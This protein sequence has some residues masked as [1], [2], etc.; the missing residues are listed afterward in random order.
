MQPGGP[1]GPNVQ[2]GG[3]QGH[4]VQP[5]GPQGPYMQQSGPQ[6]P[7]MQQSGPQGP[8]VQSGGPEGPYMQ[9]AGRQGSRMQTVGPQGPRMQT[10]GPQGPRVQSVG[11]QGPPGVPHP[12]HGGVITRGRP[13]SQGGV[14]LKECKGKMDKKSKSKKD[15]KADQRYSGSAMPNPV[16]M[17]NAPSS[18]SPLLAGIIS[19]HDVHKAMQDVQDAMGKVQLESGRS[20]EGNSMSML[21]LHDDFRQMAPVSGG[22]GNTPTSLQ[23]QAPSVKSQYEENAQV[24]SR[25]TAPL[26]L[27]GLEAPHVPT[28]RR[29]MRPPY[30][31][32]PMGSR[33]SAFQPGIPMQHVNLPERDSFAPG[34]ADPG[35]G[36]PPAGPIPGVPY[37]GPT[38]DSE[39]AQAQAKDQ[40]K[41]DKRKAGFK[42]GRKLLGEGLKLGLKA[43]TGDVSVGDLVDAGEG[44][45]SGAV[46][47]SSDRIE[48]S[49]AGPMPVVPYGTPTLD[50]AQDK[51]DKKKSRA[52]FGL[53][54]LSKGLKLGMAAPNAGG[55][56]N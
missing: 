53:N 47:Y 39:Q 17:Q 45:A 34:V 24:L 55:G 51:V 44:V 49:S 42:F 41:K 21:Q 14:P 5:G 4:N 32:V 23:Y 30:A 33:A 11:P 54:M 12:Q 31:D 19:E 26:P 25:Q 29:A 16:S 22:A 50:F 43:A 13:G 35:M 2:P 6:G 15:K 48:P 18:L 37:G 52:K 56:F 7:Y 10:V 20:S 38:L 40:A 1:Q 28:D 36:S 3:P 9:S 46:Q 8:N 27:G